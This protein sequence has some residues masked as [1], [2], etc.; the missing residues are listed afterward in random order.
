MPQSG[1]N[2]GRLNLKVQRE[3]ETQK[4]PIIVPDA[5]L[6]KG[7]DRRSDSM[8]LLLHMYHRRWNGPTIFLK[9]DLK[10]AVKL[11]SWVSA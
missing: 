4:E 10:V 3:K 2:S 9:K 1:G 5:L 8:E 7:L 11:V 6:A